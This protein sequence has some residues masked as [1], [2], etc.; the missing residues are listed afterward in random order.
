MIA[1]AYG[2]RVVAIDPDS[3]ARALAAT[4]G[5]DVVL[6]DLKSLPD[7]LRESTDGG[8]H[9]SIEAAGDPVAAA[10]SVASLRPRGRHVQIGLLPANHTSIPMGIVIGRELQILGSHGMQAH[11]YPEMLGMILDGRLQPQHLITRT[12]ALSEVPQA[13]PGMGYEKEAGVTVIDRMGG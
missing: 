6:G 4:I 3:R 11:R 8:P 9:L 1:H 5:A 2:A 7:A 10:A 12:I 13:L